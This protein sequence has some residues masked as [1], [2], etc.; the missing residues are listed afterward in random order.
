MF[1]GL[2]PLSAG[3]ANAIDYICHD[4]RPEGRGSLPTAERVAYI[5]VRNVPRCPL[6]DVAKIMETTV[7]DAEDLK[8]LAGVP[9]QGTKI[10]KPVFRFILSWAFDEDPSLDEVCEAVSEYLVAVG[11]D[12]HQVLFTVHVDTD[13][14]H[15]HGVANRVHTQTGRAADV[16]YAG[17]IGQVWARSWEEEHGGVR[18]PRRL[19]AEEAQ[20][21]RDL[22]RDQRR[23]Q[24]GREVARR[25]Q[26]ALAAWIDKRRTARGEPPAARPGRSDLF[27]WPRRESSEDERA[28][29]H[30]QFE[31]HRREGTSADVRRRERLE[32]RRRIDGQRRNRQQAIRERGAAVDI[33][34]DILVA[35]KQAPRGAGRPGSQARWAFVEQVIVPV[36]EAHLRE[37]VFARLR[38][39]VPVQVINEMLSEERSSRNCRTQPHSLERYRWCDDCEDRQVPDIRYLDDLIRRPEQ[40]TRCQQIRE[41]AIEAGVPNID[42]YASQKLPWQMAWQPSG[43]FSSKPIPHGGYAQTELRWTYLERHAIPRWEAVWSHW[44]AALRARPRV[45]ERKLAAE[46]HGTRAVEP[47]WIVPR[48]R[49]V[50][51]GSNVGG[52][53]PVSPGRAQLPAVADTTARP[54]RD[55]SPARS[56][57]IAETSEREVQTQDGWLGRVFAFFR[58]VGRD[59]KAKKEVKRKLR[60]DHIP[61]TPTVPE[62]TADNRE[63][64]SDTLK[65]ASTEPVESRQRI[66]VPAEPTAKSP[67]PKPATPPLRP[68]EA[69]GNRDVTPPPPR[70]A[71]RSTDQ[72]RGT[73]RQRQS[74]PGPGPSR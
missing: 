9:P 11:L 36:A 27:R 33:D 3:F 34:V 47:E 69:G 31:R 71:G 22:W 62:R 58:D 4:P 52:A 64:V 74:K 48:R 66:R 54:V 19:T 8:A 21:W 43:E 29:W 61:R 28:Q 23:E 55:A 44:K 30:E 42:A 17:L 63:P 1:V 12:T 41:R 60:L 7:A 35:A 39:R 37:T 32:L 45:L 20:A 65:V 49:S 73:R 16:W 5:G 38:N 72:F 56:E 50:K 6:G 46:A 53:R 2:P 57:P 18:C 40:L 26:E 70:P 67:S 68:V 24:V 59:R 51:S 25:E 10:W 14:V 15:T 13:C